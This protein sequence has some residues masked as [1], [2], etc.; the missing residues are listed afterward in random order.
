MSVSLYFLLFRLLAVCKNKS[1]CVIIKLN[2]IEFGESSMLASKMEYMGDATWWDE[3]FRSRKN[4][5][6]LP[7]EKLKSDLKYFAESKKILDLACGDG[8]NAIFWAKMGYEVY[9]VDFSTEALNR[10][11]Y[12]AISERLEIVTKLMDITSK[13]EVSTLEIKVD[14]VIVNHYRMAREIYPILLTWIND[15]G[16]LWVNGFEDV[17]EDNP[18]IREQDILRDSDFELLKHC[19]L[20]DKEKYAVGERKFVRYAWKNF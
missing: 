5:L 19:T 17:P 14:A 9:A 3:R 20:L 16:I 1:V 12:F 8:R 2:N 7:E 11:K 15:G 4:V 18:N 10:L 13:E 6:M